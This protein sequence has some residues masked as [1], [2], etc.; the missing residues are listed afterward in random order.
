MDLLMF[1]YVHVKTDSF[2]NKVSPFSVVPL[3]TSASHQNSKYSCTFPSAIK[4]KSRELTNDDSAIMTT[5]SVTSKSTID[6]GCRHDTASNMSIAS[7]VV[8]H[9]TGQPITFPV[10]SR[11]MSRAFLLETIRQVLEIM[12]ND[13]FDDGDDDCLFYCHDNYVGEIDRRQ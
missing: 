11:P 4:K 8:S 2:P 6:K 13:F 12:D 10:A 7:M 1:C 5:H 9:P 3:S